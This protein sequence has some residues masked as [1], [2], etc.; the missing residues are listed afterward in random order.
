[1]PLF[2]SKH[3][4]QTSPICVIYILPKEREELGWWLHTQAPV[5]TEKFKKEMQVK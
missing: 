3:F 5:A 4:L 2:K 1:M